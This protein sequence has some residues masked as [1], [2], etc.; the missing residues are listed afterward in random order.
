[1]W[2]PTGSQGVD[3]V[4]RP[5]AA[6]GLCMGSEPLIQVAHLLDG[7]GVGVQAK[8]GGAGPP[9]HFVSVH[10]GSQAA[11]QGVYQLGFRCVLGLLIPSSQS[12]G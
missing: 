11:H 7:L 10:P 6:L 3:R 8:N 9:K 1:M 12:R 2:S 4:V 5:I